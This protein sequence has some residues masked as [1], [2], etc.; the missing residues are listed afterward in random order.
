MYGPTWSQTG[1]S[2]VP[3][4][5]TRKKQWSHVVPQWSQRGSL[6]PHSI[7]PMVPY[8]HGVVLPGFRE[9][10][11]DN[12]YG[13]TWSRSGPGGVP[14]GFRAPHEKHT[15]YAV[16]LNPPRS[17]QTGEGFTLTSPGWFFSWFSYSALHKG[18]FAKGNPHTHQ[19]RARLPP[20]A[21]ITACK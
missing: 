4:G 1:P 15:F 5:P 16:N 3:C 19:I 21:P 7:I 6:W 17:D 18:R 14:C 9:A 2:G 11:V 8:A 10:P 13:P 20:R 12:S